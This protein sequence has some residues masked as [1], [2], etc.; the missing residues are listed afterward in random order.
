MLH[1]HAVHGL[2][3]PVEFASPSTS[4]FRAKKKSYGELDDEAIC[5]YNS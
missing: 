2:L 4:E 3:H 1:L 5:E